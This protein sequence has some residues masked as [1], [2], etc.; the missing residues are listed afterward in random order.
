[1][2]RHWLGVNTVQQ[3]RA[4]ATSLRPFIDASDPL[5]PRLVHSSY[6]TRLLVG[7][8]QFISTWMDSFQFASL[9]ASVSYLVGK[10]V[11]TSMSPPEL[12]S[13]MTG[14]LDSQGGEGSAEVQFL[15][16]RTLWCAWDAKTVEFARQRKEEREM[17]RSDS[18]F[19]RRG[20]PSD[21]H[22]D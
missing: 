18:Y 13:A 20:I 22:Q 6:S 2:N 8:V 1:M 7:R 19:G 3:A 4:S 12:S 15:S 9:M 16:V 5:S 17:R 11:G 14:S 21:P 10:K